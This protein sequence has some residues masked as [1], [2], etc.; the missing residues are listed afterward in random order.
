M[1]QYLVV[2]G[3]AGCGKSSLGA[4]LAARCGVRL[5]EGDDFHGATSRAKM[6]RGEP[7]DDGDR[8]GWLATLGNLLRQSPDGAV[9]SC[10]ALRLAYRERLREAV[11]GLRFIYLEI[12]RDEAQRR[13]AARGKTHFFPPSLVDSQFAALESP[14]GEDG[15]L[16]VDGTLSL[17]ECAAQAA[18]WLAGQSHGA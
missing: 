8:A 5:I 15:V 2:M 6:Q 10:S 4:M 16:V 1:Q 9:L 7:L 18:A 14:A 13:V 17:A 12:T 11:P 3:V